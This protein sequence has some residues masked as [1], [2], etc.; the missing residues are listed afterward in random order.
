M[1]FGYLTLQL[2]LVVIQVVLKAAVKAVAI[3]AASVNLTKELFL[4]A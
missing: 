4:E 3:E 2:L 1:L